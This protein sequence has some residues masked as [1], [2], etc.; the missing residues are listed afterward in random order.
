VTGRSG[1]RDLVARMARWRIGWRWW[2]VALSPLAFLGV[3]LGVIAASGEPMPR[4][5]DFARFSGLPSTAGV[6]GVAVLIIGVGGFGEEVGWRG[7]AL[8]RLQKRFSP[9]TSTLI[10]TACWAGWHIP[11][12]FVLESYRNFSL[13]IG[14]GFVLGLACGG[15]IATWL[16]NRTG[17]SI[18]ALAVWHGTYNIA[19]GTQAA[20]AHSATIA[21]IVSALIMVQAGVLVA[22]ELRASHQ[23][24][25]SI[26]ASD[27]VAA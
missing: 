9:L 25:R 19:A 1:I 22:L 26:L 4:F 5:S 2:L 10:L 14:I 11:Q 17:G 24:K 20:T 23:K 13:G 21:S 15:V 7:Y 8:P 6:V 18:L 16:Y 3:A 27:P 12:F